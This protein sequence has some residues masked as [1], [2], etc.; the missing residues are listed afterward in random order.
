MSK[1]RLERLK[2]RLDENEE[3]KRQYNDVFEDQMKCGVIEVVDSGHIGNVT[4]LPHREVIR[5]DKSTK[6]RTVFT[7][8]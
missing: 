2:G 8:V 3:L 1:K 6:L 4:Y 7:Q 5:R